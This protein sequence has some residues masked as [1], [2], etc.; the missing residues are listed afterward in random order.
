MYNY[1]MRTYVPTLLGIL[2][3][4]PQLAFAGSQTFTS[5][6][7]F[8]VPSYGTLTVTV[9]GAGGGGQGGRISDNPG[10][11]GAAGS[12][13]QFGQAIGYGGQGG[14]GINSG[15]L[16]GS[17]SAI[18]GA[19][20]APG[21]A[22]GG[23]SNI[24]GGGSP[25]GTGGSS[26]LSPGNCGH[27]YNGGA[28]GLSIKTYSAGA[29]SGTISVTV[30]TGGAG[31]APD[32]YPQS[33]YGS[34]GSPGSVVISWT[35]PLLQCNGVPEVYSTPGT[36]ARTVPAYSSMAV[37]VWGA[38]GGG[39]GGG[40]TGSSA[41]AGAG[42][43][44]GGYARTQYS[45]GQV[46][47]PITVRVGS[48]GSGGPANPVYTYYPNSS[49]PS[50]YIAGLW[51]TNLTGRTGESS[52]F[53]SF[54]SGQGGGGGTGDEMVLGGEGF[55]NVIPAG[56]AGG[57]GT[58]TTVSSGGSGGNGSSGGNGYDT[59][60][61]GVGSPSGA[62]GSGGGSGGVG[63]ASAV[64]CN[65]GVS[66]SG[67]GGGG[68]G[69][70]GARGSCATAGAA[71]ANGQVKI[72]C[73][74]SS[75]PTT[76]T[77]TNPV[78][79][80]GTAAAGTSYTYGFT[81]TTPNNPHLIRYAVDWDNNGS[82]DE[83]IP[84]TGY[85][86]SGS[87]GDTTHATSSAGTMTFRVQTI[88]TIDGAHDANYSSWATFSKTVVNPAPTVLLTAS[89][90]S[91]TTGQ[92]STLTWSSSNATSCTGTNFSTGGAVSGTR[93]V[94]PLVTTTYSIS[95]TGPGGTGSD[96]KTVT[97]TCTPTNICS[98]NTVV[99]S[100][101]G[102]TVQSCSY[103]C[104]AGACITPPPPSFNAGSGTTGHLQVKPQIVPKSGTATVLWNVSN[105]SA[106][107]VTGS[108]GQ[109][110]NAISGSST[111]LPITQQTTF[112][113]ACTP[114]S[115]QSFTPETQVVNVTPTFQER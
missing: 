28:G 66:G 48:G 69:G 30:G 33:N 9:N 68:S 105:V 99:N 61:T 107:S 8:T 79:W 76:P 78:S 15:P 19:D 12:L 74:Q 52:S 77:W 4:L 37:E 34:P 91:I 20:G 40:A 94:S 13:S 109:T 95:C 88:D 90:S 81:A 80:P 84:A 42:G 16:Y 86:A 71:G 10:Q 70:T 108:N 31:G 111:T 64:A 51:G 45:T 65:P 82:I 97:F 98:G 38:G 47:G 2:I 32:F 21:G 17:C 35:D 11:N 39:A 43:G 72:T 53:G 58:G 3:F 75:P 23:D 56:G 85:T 92:S 106:C 60:M 5:S 67:P 73:S 62:G 54:V 55:F 29:I 114:Y 36:Y 100:C 24:Q 7:T 14:I 22:V 49:G 104:G 27:G 25:G 1:R 6:G 18:R 101:T 112:T 113:L 110:W 26:P 46:S 59:S 44:G 96:V 87:E 102:A 115:G 103:Q 57:S 83:Y 41:H 93:S 63:G 89:S 50:G